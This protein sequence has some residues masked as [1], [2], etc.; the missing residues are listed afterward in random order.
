[1]DTYLKSVDFSLVGSSSVYAEL[2]YLGESVFR[3]TSVQNDYDGVD[4]GIFNSESEIFRLIKTYYHDKAS[5]RE[6]TYEL[7]QALCGKGDIAENYRV[8]FRSYL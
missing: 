3:L 2:V 7:G 1:M 4:W 8:F 5:F 6:T